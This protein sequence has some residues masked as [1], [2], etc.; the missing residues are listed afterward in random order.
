M[1]SNVLNS[2]IELYDAVE[3][4]EENDISQEAD[5]IQNDLIPFSMEYYLD[6]QKLSNVDNMP[7]DD[8]E[9]A[10]EEE[11]NKKKKHK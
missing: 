8:D 4:N 10:E 5:F 11:D 1:S 9:E 2:Q 3:E 6:L 7:E